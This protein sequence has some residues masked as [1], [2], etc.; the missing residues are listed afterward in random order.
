MGGSAADKPQQHSGHEAHLVHWSGGTIGPGGTN[1][2]IVRLFPGGQPRR[3]RRIQRI[4]LIKVAEAEEIG[5]M[6]GDVAGG[7]ARIFSDGTLTL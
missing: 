1:A 6:W 2:S 7:I 4:G 3:D 5:L